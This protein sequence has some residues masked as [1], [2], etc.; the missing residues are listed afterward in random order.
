MLTTNT[1]K[2]TTDSTTLQWPYSREWG[3]MAVGGGLGVANA[4]RHQQ[5]LCS[6]RLLLL[7]L[8]INHVVLHPLL[9]L[10]E[11]HRHRQ[12]PLLLLL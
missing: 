3:P 6:H 11:G 1:T 8:L 5:E 4:S 12:R 2:S 10:M 9:L 7:L